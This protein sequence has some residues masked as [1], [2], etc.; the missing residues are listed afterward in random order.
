MMT[1]K[2]LKELVSLIP[3]DAKVGIGYDENKQGEF[4]A[5]DLITGATVQ[6]TIK[7]PEC[8]FFSTIVESTIIFDV[9]GAGQQ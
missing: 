6:T 2:Q 5:P 8:M 9:K 3:D 4:L 1:G 7:F